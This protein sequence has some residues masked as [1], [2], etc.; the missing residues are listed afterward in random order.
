M[1]HVKNKII[2]LVMTCTYCG[3]LPDLFAPGY[4]NKE[5]VE[6]ALLIKIVNSWDKDICYE[7]E[8]INDNTMIFTYSIGYIINN[9][10]KKN[11]L[12]ILLEQIFGSR[13]LSHKI[14]LDKSNL[15][16]YSKFKYNQGDVYFIFENLHWYNIKHLFNMMGINISG[17]AV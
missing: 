12:L 15:L 8:Q 17:V 2:H 14:I 11:N 9:L 10:G 16:Y 1:I 4:F 3:S 6:K 7:F 13:N 5:I